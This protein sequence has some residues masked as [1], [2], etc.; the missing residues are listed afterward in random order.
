MKKMN[1]KIL[2]VAILLFHFSI[3]DAQ[4][5]YDVTMSNDTVYNHGD[6]QFICKFRPGKKG[7]LYSLRSLDNK[8]QALF[9]VQEQTNNWKFSATFT[10]LNLHYG[11][12]YPKME[13][14]TLMDSYIRNK[15][16][17][18][19][20]PNLEG[21][22]AYCKERSLDLV[23]M[24]HKAQSRALRDSTLAA[25]ARLDAANQIKFT[26]H[27]NADKPVRV[28]IGDKPK[29][30]SGRIQIIAP[31]G[32]LAEHVRKTEKIFLLNDAGDGIKSV[33]GM[34]VLPRLVIKS[35]ADGFE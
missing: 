8:T 23:T 26:F 3:S 15:V 30:G 22:K 11:C 32:D 12:L 27:N 34:D 5:R 6:A 31:H 28:F 1:N 18:N 19:G 13:I 29:G 35:T 7:D 10:T 21:L 17:L 14:L 33:P 4:E 24:G 20:M 16:F 9:I 2:L 25:N